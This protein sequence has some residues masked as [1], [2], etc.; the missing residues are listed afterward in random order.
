MVISEEVREFIRN[1]VTALEGLVE[2]KRHQIE[3]T[4][5]KPFFPTQ[6]PVAVIAYLGERGI[7]I[8]F[9]RADYFDILVRK[10]EKPHTKGQWN[11]FIPYPLFERIKNRAFEKAKSDIERLLS[12]PKIMEELEQETQKYYEN[13]WMEDMRYTI[14]HYIEFLNQSKEVLN[15]TKDEAIQEL[16]NIIELVQNHLLNFEYILQAGC[17]ALTRVY[18]MINSDLETSFFL[19]LHGKYCS[20][21]AH[22]RRVLEVYVRCIYL[23]S[24][25]D[26]GVAEKKLNDWL[27]GGRFTKS[28]QK[29]INCLI[30]DETDK[31]VTSLLEQLST[32]ENES[33]KNSIL[34]LYR[35]LCVFVHLRPPTRW[36]DDLIFSFSEFSLSKFRKYYATLKKVIKLAEILLVLKFPKI[37][38][39]QRVDNPTATYVGLTLSKQEL[40]NIA[41]ISIS[42]S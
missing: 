28:F 3:S 2:K 4:S 23:D 41:K 18:F 31:S 21:I 7:C 30:S 35:E 29:V 10:D 9:F 19:A 25:H 39:T 17:E 32:L 27:N 5:I 24:F 34:S 6:F 16:Y 36:E 22:L 40:E 13:L 1:Y 11:E 38:S 37:I 15:K 20:A 33:F 12:L 26:R 42:S 8:H 14:E